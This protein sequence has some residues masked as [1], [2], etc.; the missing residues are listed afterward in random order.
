[1]SKRNRVA[2]R[3][4]L[5]LFLVLAMVSVSQADY[6]INNLP[7]RTQEHSNWCWA[8][9]TQAILNYY[10]QTPTQCQEANWNFGRSDCCGNTTFSWS[11]PCNSGSNPTGGRPS[12]QAVLSHWGVQSNARSYALS[13]TTVR[14][15]SNAHRP[16]YVSWGWTSGGGHGM[17]GYGYI[18]SGGTGYVYYMDPWPGE[19]KKVA[20]Y[21]FFR[22]SSDHNWRASC[23]ITTPGEAV[24]YMPKDVTINNPTPTYEWFAVP[25]ATWYELWV[26]GTS[27]TVFRQWLSSSEYSVSGGYVSYRP[28]VTLANG[29]YTWGIRTWNSNG[30]GPWSDSAAFVQGTADRPTITSPAAGSTL[31]GSAVTFRWEYSGTSISY[32]W[33]YVGSAAGGSDIHNSGQ[34][35][36]G[37]RSHNVTGIPTDGRQVY[38]RL[39]YYTGGSWK[40]LDVQYKAATITGTPKIT[41]PTPGTTLSG[42]TVTFGWTDNGVSVSQWW[43]YVGSAV[44]GNDIY[45]SGSISAGTRSRTVSGI[46]TDG[47]AIYVQLWYYSSGGWKYVRAE[48]TA[49]TITTAPKMTSPVPGSTL[50]SS[51][52]TFMWQYSGSVS[53]WWMYVGSTQGAYDIHNSGQMSASTRAHNVSGIPT[54]GRTVYVRLW[55]DSGGWKYVDVQYKAA[56][57]TAT[58]KITSPVP[59]TTL[60]GSSVTFSW[61]YSGSSVTYFWMYVGSSLA[62]YDIHSSGQMSAGTRSRTVSGIPTDGRQVYVRLWYYIGGWQYVDVQYTA[63]SATCGFDEQFNSGNAASWR[64]DYGSWSVV[65]S[66]WYHTAGVIGKSATSTYNATYSNVDYRA[67]L[68]RSATNTFSNRLLVRASGAIGSDGN[69][70]N[71]YMFQYSSDGTYSVWK[72]VGGVSTAIKYWTASS[73]INKGAAWNELRAYVS[74]SALYF[75]INGYTVWSGTDSS[76]SSGRVGLGMYKSDS[77]DGEL[78]VDYATLGCLSGA[79]EGAD[80]GISGEISAEQQELNAAEVAGPILDEN[81][82][83]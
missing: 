46:P 59:G 80:Q 10:E 38:V 28:S 73:Y 78:W 51:S 82:S 36:S 62:A 35:S 24:L 67:R 13:E 48:Y 81:G 16:F 25:G 11:H 34:L 1:M 31:A 60:A 22:S 6:I 50:S 58:P 19:G 12:S 2:K 3:L 27:G 76:L 14:D 30:Y 37:T 18:Q 39:W 65:S 56:T 64:R 4:W 32:F 41:I 74:G 63:A 55:Y 69:Y 57:I 40:Y 83:Q 53:R 8:G 7:T 45:N 17:A 52:V 68:W 66:A 72:R 26:Q 70:A 47:R 9:T 44:G 75:A 21:T 54:D 23:Q 33:L 77:T 5:T 61:E 49:A 71:C 15:E 79:G 29:N 43:L 20:T 42:S